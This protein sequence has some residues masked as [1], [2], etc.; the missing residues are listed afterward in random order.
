M[1]TVVQ[2]GDHKIDKFDLQTQLRLNG[3]DT[4]LFLRLSTIK[5]YESFPQ[6]SRFLRNELAGDLPA[7]YGLNLPS[8]YGLSNSK[9][10]YIC[11]AVLRITQSV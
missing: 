7:L 8:R 5:A 11:E 3:I 4:C 6:S 1:V 10:T 2:K 9:I